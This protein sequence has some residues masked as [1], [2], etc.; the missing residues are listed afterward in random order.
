MAELAPIWF[1]PETEKS[2]EEAA[3][4]QFKLRPLSSV[5]LWE[6][7]SH[8]KMIDADHIG[9]SFEGQKA[10]VKFGLIDWKNVQDAEGSNA[11][12]NITNWH[13]LDSWTLNFISREIIAISELAEAERKN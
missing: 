11:K 4:K 13:L 12:C 10:A 7:N 5:Q 1:T 6:V 3:Q 9:M 8:M 2:K